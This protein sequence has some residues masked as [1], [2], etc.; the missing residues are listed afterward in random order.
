MKDLSNCL[1]PKSVK[2]QSRKP[3]GLQADKPYLFHTQN[4]GKA[5]GFTHQER[6]RKT[7]A[8]TPTPKGSMRK[9]HYTR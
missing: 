3:Q 5:A 2:V 4:T 9:R 7:H 8:S 1:P 6:F